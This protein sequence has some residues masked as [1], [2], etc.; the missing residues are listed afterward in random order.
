M[1]TAMHDVRRDPP[2]NG[3]SSRGLIAGA[4]LVMVATGAPAA[5][6]LGQRDGVPCVRNASEPEHGTQTVQLQELWRVAAGEEEG[7]LLGRIRRAITDEEGQVYL[8]DQQLA[9]VHVFS[10]DGVYLHSLS[11]EGEGPGES[12]NPMDL[13]FTPDGGIGLVQAFP[14][15][16]VVVD[17]EGDPLPAIEL[18]GAG[19]AGN[20]NRFALQVRNRGGT[21]AYSGRTF[22]MEPGGAKP[23]NLLVTCDPDGGERARILETVTDDVVETRRWVEKDD[24]FPHRDRWEIGP[25]GR[26]FAAPERDRYAIHIYEPDGTQERIVEREYEARRR[27]DEEK[28]D[29]GPHINVNGSDLEIEEVVEDRAPCIDRIHVTDSGELWVRHSWSEREQP[30]GVMQT[31]DVF[32]VDGNYDRRVALACAESYDYENDQLFRIDDERFILIKGFDPRVRISIG[33][34]D[35]GDVDDE[36]GDRPPLEVICY[37]IAS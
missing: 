32:D 18:R 28:Q 20:G 8:L 23:R 26:L 7:F 1:T 13:L 19:A 22:S 36:V 11:R 4:L 2:L 35:G 37:R 33:G 29:L 17:R 24:Y 3:W 31:L 34:D 6:E 10:P 5:G 12:R 16:V 27:T 9:Q 15:R 30:A 21:F 25:R 14:A